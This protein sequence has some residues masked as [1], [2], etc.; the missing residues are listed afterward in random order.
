M[1]AYIHAA[2]DD[3]QELR[4]VF[5]VLAFNGAPFCCQNGYGTGQTMKGALEEFRK[6]KTVL[7]S[8]VYLP[9]DAT[10]T[11]VTM[12]KADGKVKITMHFMQIPKDNF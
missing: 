4:D 12:E 2:R 1:F 11:G 7:L 3:I 6:Q 8:A 5:V 10:S 9:K